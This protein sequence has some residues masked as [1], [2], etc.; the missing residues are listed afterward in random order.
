MI[1]KTI[2]DVTPKYS[3]KYMQI[4]YLNNIKIKYNIIIKKS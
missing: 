3:K 2:N 1:Y 4:K